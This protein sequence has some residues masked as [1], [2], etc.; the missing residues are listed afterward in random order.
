MKFNKGLLR[1]KKLDSNSEGLLS[2]Q[3]HIEKTKVGT[4]S[5]NSEN[6]YRALAANEVG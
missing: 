2:F 3:I 6:E 1:L 5:E 4:T